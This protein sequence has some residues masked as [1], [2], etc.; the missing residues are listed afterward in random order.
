[1]L[2]K[3]RKNKCQ[4]QREPSRLTV[5]LGKQTSR[6]IKIQQVLVTKMKTYLN[7]VNKIKIINK[8]LRNEM[9]IILRKMVIIMKHKERKKDR[10]RRK[11]MFKRIKAIQNQ[12]Q[13]SNF[14]SSMS[15]MPFTLFR[16]KSMIIMPKICSKINFRILRSHQVPSNFKSFSKPRLM[17]VKILIILAT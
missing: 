7:L 3:R 2:R 9:Q 11:R 12:D 6:S 1:M 8:I 14:K 10:K 16:I 5:E 4:V 17:Q 15:Q 13:K